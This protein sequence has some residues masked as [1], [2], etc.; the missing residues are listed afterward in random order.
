M[1]TGAM[2]ARTETLP[3]SPLLMRDELGH[4]LMEAL[5]ELE[6]LPAAP[7]AALVGVYA[8]ID[9]LRRALDRAEALD[10]RRQIHA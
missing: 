5:Y 6:V 4:A 1:L 8:I 10:A 2:H 9:D 7:D 3:S